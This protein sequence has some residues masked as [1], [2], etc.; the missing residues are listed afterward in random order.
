MTASAAFRSLGALTSVAVSAAIL[1]GCAVINRIDG[2]SQAEDLRASGVPATATILRIWDTGMT[3]N[4]DPV[5][6]FLLQVHRQDGADYEAET[7][8]L[9]SR[10]QI[11]QIQPGAVVSVRYDRSNPARVSLDLG[12]RT[13]VSPPRFSPTPPPPAAEMEAEKQRLLATGVEG[14][15]TI[16]QCQ[17]LGLFDS[18]GR[19]VY[20]LVLSLEVP[21][22]APT[23]GPARVGVLRERE[24]WFKVGQRLPIKAD[25][26]APS[27]FAVD[28]PRLE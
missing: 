20:D 2:L 17:P 14:T 6:G 5:V 12:T 19:P 8:L 25:P 4:D 16:L 27:H 23:Q 1:S 7:R 13:A 18:D 28:W 9:I 3:V 15:A 26:D 22:H 11:P 24:H 10:L 21:G